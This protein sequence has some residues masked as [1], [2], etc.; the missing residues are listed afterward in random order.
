VL[1]SEVIALLIFNP[2][3]PAK[4]KTELVMVEPWVLIFALLATVT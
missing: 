4:A 3:L 2:E 1:A